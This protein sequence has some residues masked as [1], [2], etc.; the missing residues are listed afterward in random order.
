MKLHVIG[1]SSLGNGYVLEENNTAL[2]IE[3]GVPLKKML[4]FIDFDLDKI[5]C[6][7]VTHSH[8]DHCGFINQYLD[9]GV[10]VFNNINAH[11]NS[12]PIKH[13]RMIKHDSWRVIPLKM[14][15]D[16][17]CYGFLIKSPLGIT[18]FFATDTSDIPYNIKGINHAIIEA[19][20]EQEHLDNKQVNHKINH[21]LASRV[22]QSHLSYEKAKD[23]LVKNNDSLKTITLIHLS[24]S[25]SLEKKFKV[26]L[27]QTLG[28]PVEIA[29]TGDVFNLEF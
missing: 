24:D 1:S 26:N 4:P 18:V 8:G 2:L 13:G 12:Y 9:R 17:E 3:C 14:N 19:N 29:D 15:H 23:W 20:F 28:V 7:L 22:E 16:V 21:A 25:N 6:A 11:Y 10:R 5:S 27:Q